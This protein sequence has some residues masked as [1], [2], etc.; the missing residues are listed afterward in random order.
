MGL[1]DDW[2]ALRACTGASPAPPGQCCTRSPPAAGRTR[3]SPVMETAGRGL[4]SLPAGWVP[5]QA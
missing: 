3:P 2:P 4:S 1:F 5:C